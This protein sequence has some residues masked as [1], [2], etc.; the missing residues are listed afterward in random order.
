MHFLIDEHLPLFLVRKLAYHATHVRERPGQGSTAS[1]VAAWARDNQAVIVTKD[2][3]FVQQ[4]G[5]GKM[6]VPVIWI[7]AGNTANEALWTRF[8]KDLPRLEALLA[9]GAQIVETI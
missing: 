2:V 4:A 9:S 7:R 1:E 8:V 5:L 6:N 3:D